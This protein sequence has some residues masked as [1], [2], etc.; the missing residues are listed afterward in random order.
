MT[1]WR[2]VLHTAV[3]A[4]RR[5]AYLAN[6]RAE[7]ITSLAV[8]QVSEPELV[9]LSTASEDAKSACQYP[10]ETLLVGLDTGFPNETQRNRVKLSTLLQERD[11]H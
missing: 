6:K 1:L 10:L 4:Q 8:K 5:E 3:Q 11:A 9:E 2:T 7:G